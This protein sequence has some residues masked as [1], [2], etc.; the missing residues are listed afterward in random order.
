[1]AHIAGKPH[2]L[3]KSNWPLLP[4]PNDYKC[5]HH[6][7]ASINW[8]RKSLYSS[9]SHRILAYTQ[10]THIHQVSS[11]FRHSQTNAWSLL[12]WKLLKS[13]KMVSIKSTKK[14]VSRNMK[15]L[16]HMRFHVPLKLSAFHWQSPL[17]SNKHMHKSLQMQNPSMHKYSNTVLWELDVAEHHLRNTTSNPPFCVNY[18]I[19][20]G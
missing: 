11:D 17:Y 14:N 15:T 9:T 1:M 13:S 12:K 6:V 10:C 8:S 2:L 7:Y 18:H 3:K 19:F 20:Y 4:L 16:R 5:F